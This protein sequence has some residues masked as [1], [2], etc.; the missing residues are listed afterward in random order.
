MPKGETLIII[1][2]VEYAIIAAAFGI[3]SDWARVLYYI[4]AIIISL[5][6]LWMK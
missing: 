6:V 2:I 3:Q 1:L 4:G 5:G